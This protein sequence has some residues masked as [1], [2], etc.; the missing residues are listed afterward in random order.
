MIRGL[1]KEHGF[2]VRAFRA[3]VPTLEDVFLQLTGHAMRD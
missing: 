2:Q 1:A 3:G